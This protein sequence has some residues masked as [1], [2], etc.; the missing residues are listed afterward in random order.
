M[1]QAGS[2][3]SI[4]SCPTY[5]SLPRLARHGCDGLRTSGLAL[6]IRPPR[7]LLPSDSF[8]C[9]HHTNHSTEVV[10]SAEH[11]SDSEPRP[12]PTGYLGPLRAKI[13]RPLYSPGQNEARI[14]PGPNRSALTVPRHIFKL[15][16]CQALTLPG[17]S[18]PTVIFST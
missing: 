12:R 2:D 16:L 14:L 13:G 9:T 17:G 11:S 5:S 10:R 8:S 3:R 6:K 1:Y 18:P 7:T 4:D 15:F